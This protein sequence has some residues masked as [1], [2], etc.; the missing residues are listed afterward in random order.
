MYSMQHPTSSEAQLSAD[1]RRDAQQSSIKTSE[2]ATLFVLILL[3]A[4]LVSHKLGHLKYAT[5]GSVSLLVGVAAGG[6]AVLAVHIF[7]TENEEQ[8]IRSL[9][10][11]REDLFLNTLLPVII[12]FSGQ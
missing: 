11:F 6:L 1:F 10:E 5:E 3:A 2:R 4:S 7:N 8:F 9:V 12:F